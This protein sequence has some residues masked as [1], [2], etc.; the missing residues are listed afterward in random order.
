M[1]F[2]YSFRRR[3]GRIRAATATDLLHHLNGDREPDDTGI[4]AGRLERLTGASAVYQLVTASP[5]ALAAG[6][7]TVAGPLVGL[8]QA[9]FTLGLFYVPTIT[10]ANAAATLTFS[11]RRTDTPALISTQSFLTATADTNPRGPTL[12]AVV[13]FG[14][15]A[16]NGIDAQGQASAG[17]GTL[18][19]SVTAPLILAAVGIS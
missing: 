18:T 11:I 17:A 9:P 2:P 4:I 15:P 12:I 16:T 8:P 6:A 7:A 1:I 5:A 19:A 13:P 10:G 3:F 14:I